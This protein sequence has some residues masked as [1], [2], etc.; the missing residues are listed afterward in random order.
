MSAAAA[1]LCLILGA[2]T[3]TIETQRFT[4][5]WTHSVEKTEWQEDYVARDGGLALVEA[6]IQGT[7]AGMEPPPDAILRDGWWHY[8]PDL[9]LLPELHLTL[10]P[11]TTDYRL[12]W[13]SRCR[14][15]GDLL[16]ATG[17]I[18]TVQIRPCAK[19]VSPGGTTK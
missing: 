8:V 6:R 5:A 12:C 16:G 2:K 10:S 19:P 17:E 13:D 1:A 18:G 15:L 14:R 4:L 9:P 7:G 11:F 3:A